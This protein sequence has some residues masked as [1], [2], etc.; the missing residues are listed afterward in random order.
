MNGAHPDTTYKGRPADT[1]TGLLIVIVSLPVILFLLVSIFRGQLGHIVLFAVLLLPFWFIARGSFNYFT[2]TD[3]A[4]IVGGQLSRKTVSISY[5][6]ITKVEFYTYKL[7]TLIGIN[8]TSGNYK[9]YSLN[10]L[11][12]TQVV[13]LQ[14]DLEQRGVNI[15]QKLKPY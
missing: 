10:G 5:T 14:Q 13:A 4:L 12:R 6:E 2:T 15:S 3:K 7:G 8:L 11:D 1:G 9:S